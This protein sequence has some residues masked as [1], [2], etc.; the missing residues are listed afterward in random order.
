LN[1][2]RVPPRSLEAERAVLGS[3]LRDPRVIPEVQL[4]LRPEQTDE[5]LYS[6]AH[7]L[8]YRCINDLHQRGSGLDLVLLSNKLHAQKQIDDIG[9]YEYLAQIYDEVPTAANAGYYAEIVREKAMH[10][11]LIYF[12]T[13]IAR[14]SSDG[15]APA[16]EL[17][18]QAASKI[19][20][21]LSR[22]A[23]S[24]TARIHKELHDILSDMDKPLNQCKSYNTGLASLDL[25]FG[26]E[27]G[28]LTTIGARPSVG[29]SIGVI[30]FAHNLA[31]NH[32]LP[33][34]LLSLEMTR[35]ENVQRLL[36][37]H[38]SARFTAVR[39]K[40]EPDADE[41]Q[42]ISDACD[43]LYRLPIYLNCEEMN[44]QTLKAEVLRAKMKHGIQVVCLDYL[45]LVDGLRNKGESRAEEVGRISKTLKR[46]AIEHNLI[47]IAACQLNRETERGPARPKTADLRES[48]SIEQDSD[49]VIL[50]WR[51]DVTASG[52]GLQQINGCVAKQ[53]NGPCP[54]D[55]KLNR[56]A[57]YMRFEGYIG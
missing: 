10:R 56:N 30:Q 16:E 48:G 22:G 41:F 6:Q 45:Q 57:A 54:V 49:N 37:L 26:F 33:V 14:D 44:V 13:D 17:L 4:I 2:T 21:L 47:I 36:S 31:E 15:V 3:M 34:L 20:G 25:H 43:E 38:S 39:R 28:T 46:L 23:G 51:E 9:G 7:R 50:L 35:K 18:Q 42:R 40:S 53:R 52:E 1:L 32:G 8:I 24:G 11:A 5:M 55:F 19:E 29:K 27:V 12:G